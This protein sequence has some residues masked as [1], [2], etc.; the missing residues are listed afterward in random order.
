[1]W[2]S[3]FFGC[4]YEAHL[5]EDHNIRIH[6]YLLG[7]WEIVPDDGNLKKERMMILKFSD[8]EYI[9]HYPIEGNAIYSRDY[10]VKIGGVSC[11]QL[12]AIGTNESTPDVGKKNLCHI[13]SYRLE[14]VELAIRLLNEKLVDYDPKTSAALTQSF[15][16]NKKLLV[17]PGKF[18]RVK[19]SPALPALGQ[20]QPYFSTN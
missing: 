19:K 8:T 12:Q 14:N 9:I 1:M 15:L 4:E 18:Q 13:G 20:S 3:C 17:N 16:G 2:L 7:L 6:S 10:P 5:T 11:V